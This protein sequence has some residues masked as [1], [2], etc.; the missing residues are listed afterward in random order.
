MVAIVKGKFG[1]DDS[2]DAFGVH[3]IGGTVGAILTGVFA[4]SAVNAIYKDS[5]GN[6][7]PSGLIDGHGGQVLNQLIAVCISWALAI[8]GTLV[9]LKIVDVVIGLRVSE[10]DEVQGLDVS[11]HGEEG[12]NFEA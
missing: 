11:Q 7:L 6:P 5:Q 1:Y 4:T 12:Y 2:L 3:G 9:I 10:A 8:V